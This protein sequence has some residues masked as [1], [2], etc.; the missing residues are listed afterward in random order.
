MTWDVQPSE[1]H[2]L[3]EFDPLGQTLSLIEFL[4]NRYS[5][6]YALKRA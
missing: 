6:K 1:F 3:A 5:W 4:Q 2:P